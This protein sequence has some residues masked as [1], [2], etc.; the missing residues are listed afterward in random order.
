MSIVGAFI[1]PHPPLIF[2]EIGRG[3]ERKIQK[4][5][6]A[7][8]EAA[9]RIAELKPDTIVLATPHSIMYADSFHISPGSEAEGDLRQFAPQTP[10]LKVNYDSEF[11][12]LLSQNAEGDALYAGTLGEKNARLDHGSIIP[13]HFIE[14]LY[15][16][17]HLVRVSISGLPFSDHYR[18]GKCIARTSD[19]L[20]RRTVFIASA[21]LSHRLKDDGPYGFSPEGPKFDQS[22]TKAMAE[23]DFIQMLKYASDFCEKAGECGLRSCIM[24]AGALDQ[25]D[26]NSELL[27]YE[28]PFGVGYAVAAFIPTQK[29]NQRAFLD[30]FNAEEQKQLEM[31]QNNEDPYV[32]LAR[33]A[34][35]HY[36]KTG[37]RV[38]LPADLPEDMLSEQE[39]VFVSLK[40]HGQL[41][42]CI[43]TIA[44][45]TE[46]V[47]SE[48]CRN[49]V[50][51]AVEDPRFDPI[52]QDELSKLVYSV[53]VL[54]TP[55]PID[56][57]D[58]L[59]VLHYGVIVSSG[60]KRGLLLPNL[61]GVETVQQQ[62]DIARQKAGI[63]DGES[64]KLE[65][66][67]VV[68]HK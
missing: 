26:V 37:K 2:P 62:I 16:D 19:Q 27:S 18:L 11:V 10:R 9:R 13:L 42:G 24:M 5:I 38:A 41:R 7:Y 20:Q 40:K 12:S 15:N 54:E 65:R 1:L 48:I 55:Q 34:L 4:T 66:F 30:Q 61:E 23:G 21:D 63:R 45:V 17:Y 22:I 59:D 46:N 47:A 8:R 67:K 3:E 53:D 33:S 49:A 32:R 68:R 51:A 29:N 25:M 64:F 58:Q 50:S 39:G 52:S 60:H 6:D 44:P 14:E 56:S 57:Q 35:E 36:I 28:G 31:I 43:G